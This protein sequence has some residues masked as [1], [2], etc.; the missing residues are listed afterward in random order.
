MHLLILYLHEDK[1][2]CSPFSSVSIVHFCISLYLLYRLTIFHHPTV[3]LTLGLAVELVAVGLAEAR[4]V[5]QTQT[6]EGVKSPDRWMACAG[7]G[8]HGQ[9]THSWG[10]STEES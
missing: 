10:D 3:L 1:Q 6:D 9:T 4:F 5:G 7:L 2:L 8:C